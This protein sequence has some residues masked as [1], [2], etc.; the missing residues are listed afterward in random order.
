[1]RAILNSLQV[2]WYRIT[3]REQR[4]VMIGGVALGFGLL[5][6][7]LYQPVAQ[8]AEQAQ[9]NLNSE[10]QLLSWVQDKADQIVDLRGSGVKAISPLPLNQAVSS[11]ARRFNVEMVRVQPRGEEMQV[12]VQPLPFNQLM[13][14]IEY[15]KAN[16]AID[17]L[18]LDI[19]K[20]SQ[21]GMVEVKRLQLTKG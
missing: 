14:W 5:Y 12:W 16:H 4:L 3:P 20:S 10:K 17:V 18:F 8:R 9:L 2:W 1:M 15:M 19:D 13:S 6:W 7:G 11:S 21:A